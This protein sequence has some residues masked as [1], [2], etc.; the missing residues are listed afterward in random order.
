MDLLRIHTGT[1]YE[2]AEKLPGGPTGWAVNRLIFR[3]WWHW[4]DQE[5]QAGLGNMA[6]TG[7]NEG[8]KSSLLALAATLLDGDTTPRRLDPSLS[9]DRYLHYFLLGKEHDNPENPEVFSYKARV[10]YVAMEFRRERDGRYLTIGMGVDASQAV[11]GKIREW[12]GFI[13]PGYRLGRHFDVRD[14][15]GICFGLQD[16]RQLPDLGLVVD[17]EGDVPPDAVVVTTKR[18]IYRQQVNDH[19]FKMED[20]DYR[21]LIESLVSARRP[22][23]V[24]ATQEGPE[25]VCQLLQESL[26][27]L[28]AE[29]MDNLSAVINNLE[30]HQRN[31]KDLENQ[32]EM[33]GEI[34]RR[35]YWLV[36]VLVQQAA[37][38][39]SSQLGSYANVVGRFQK[40]ENQRDEARTA[41]DGLDNKIRE[42]KTAMSLAGSELTAQRVDVAELPAQLKQA[43]SREESTGKNYLITGENLGRITKEIDEANSD[44]SHI[45]TEFNNNRRRIVLRLDEHIRVAHGLSWTEAGEVLREARDHTLTLD[46]SEPSDQAHAA[47]PDSACLIEKSQDMAERC[48]TVLDSLRVMMDRERDFQQQEGILDGL[49][50][51][52]QMAVD[53]VNR[54]GDQLAEEKE[55]LVESLEKWQDIH[56]ELELPDYRLAAVRGAVL[57]LQTV[58]DQGHHD[59]LQP[60]R[61]YAGERRSELQS[62]RQRVLARAEVIGREIDRLDEEVRGLAEKGFRPSRSV[63]RD[64]ARTEVNDVK[65]LY[66][67]VRFRPGIDPEVAALV[68]AALLE[69][70]V[71]DLVVPAGDAPLADAWLWS[72]RPVTG[73][74]LATVMESEECAPG[75]ADAALAAIGWGVG[76]GDHWVAPDGRWRHGLAEGQVA[77][78]MRETPGLVGALRRQQAL[79]ERINLL[80]EAKQS[81]EDMRM[82]VLAESELYR[83]SLEAVDRALD[84]L[85]Q[86][87]WQALFKAIHNLESARDAAQ[88]AKQAVDAARPMADAAR[89]DFEAAQ[90]LYRE[91]VRRA[92]FAGELNGDGLDRLVDGLK[93]FSQGISALTQ[94]YGS[95]EQWMKQYRYKSEQI[96]KLEGSRKDWKNQQLAAEREYLAVKA[97]VTALKQRIQDPDIAVALAA[98]QRLEDQIQQLEREIE[99]AKEDKIGQK[100]QYEAAVQQLAYLE[101]EVRTAK[102]LRDEKRSL[103][104]ERLSLHPDFAA[105]AGRLTSE[106]EHKPGSLRMLPNLV[107]NITDLQEAIDERKTELMKWFQK[108][109]DELIE[110]RPT[111]S[112]TFDRIVFFDEARRELMP[113]ELYERLVD[114]Q[115]TTRKLIGAEE[116]NLYE[117]IICNDLLDELID[118]M[119]G[120]MEFRII[121]NRK[122]EGLKSSSGA[123]FS[124]KLDF[125]ADSVPGVRVGRALDELNLVGVNWLTG[126]QRH[127]LAKLIRDEVER[128]RRE[129]Q[130]Q[131]RTV[132]YLEAIQITLDYRRWYEFRLFSHEPGHKPEPIKNRGFG[133]RSMFGRSWALAV[134]IIAGVA[135]RYDAA[136]DSDVPRI[137]FLDEVFA[138]F[139]PKNQATYL[140]YLNELKLNWIIT[141]P[142]DMPYSD[143][144]P[145]VMS[146][147]MYLSGTTHTAYPSLWDGQRVTDPFELSGQA[148]QMCVVGKKE[149]LGA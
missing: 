149:E 52:W 37:Q 112:K 51:E 109:A 8:G 11:Q 84:R 97:E 127:Q 73:P 120:A 35:H 49:R 119:A 93:E 113:G 91:A 101:P 14:K 6:L 111:H 58:P 139:D 39:Y 128:A 94:L 129:A 146:Y 70:G 102:Q 61:A 18:H 30:L 137:V 67:L 110:Y 23:I 54:A 80:Q 68:E 131:N 46:P 82:G 83:I 143:Q 124:F 28:P 132:G 81:A 96:K 33:A 27:P 26:P 53:N 55:R 13:I 1:M 145:A 114:R 85:D 87:L 136:R 19:L 141:S 105:E 118:L 107:D 47:A 76:Q 12:W 16:F 100:G 98:R 3:D 17:G 71:L 72:S 41:V 31:L 95:L 63:I 22:K 134:P 135:A 69:A 20:D 99:A 108:V 45:Q 116:R 5:L 24:Q 4:K 75:I 36:E 92:P 34:D 117:E 103:L 79:A 147:Q 42:K 123:Y 56:P 104:L 40:A 78:W 115:E 133:T 15:D 65:P 10:G 9:P 144:L 32:A 66:E 50:G 74:S 130:A 90:A 25:K 122:L 29:Q 57:D 48:R 106:A 77:P 142:E 138:G 121:M 125:Q 43:R 59:L 7:Q 88:K 2:I 64:A 60:L 21:A 126:E 38:E 148:A 44:L 62:A 89:R 86:L 140:R